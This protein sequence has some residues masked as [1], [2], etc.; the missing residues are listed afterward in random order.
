MSFSPYNNLLNYNNVSGVLTANAINVR[1]KLVLGGPVWSADNVPITFNS[2]VLFN[3]GF[4]ISADVVNQ[5]N[6]IVVGTPT[7][8]TIQSAI[9][10]FAGMNAG[11]TTITI[12]PGIYEEYIS[13]S[14]CSSG[15]N[16]QSRDFN[17]NDLLYAENVRGLQIIGDNR[18]YIPS[19][20][21]INGYENAGSSGRGRTY[22]ITTTSPSAGPFTAYIASS[23]GAVSGIGPSGAQVGNPLFGGS[24]L[25]NV[26]L[27][28][29]IALMQRGGGIGFATKTLNAQNGGGVGA[30]AAIIYNNVGTAILS[31]GGTNDAVTIPAY[32]VSLADGLTLNNLITAN[33]GIQITIS[34][35]DPIYD[36]PLGTNYAFSQILING[37]RDQLTINMV[38]PLPDY[39]SNIVA[40]PSVLVNPDFSN[41]KVGV[42]VGDRIAIS[43]SD[44]N[45]N[46][47]KSLHTIT[48]VSGNV[49]TISP[50]VDPVGSGGVDFSVAGSSVTF[51]PNVCISPPFIPDR[52]FTPLFS[53]NNVDF[54]MNGI[55]LDQNASQPFSAVLDGF[56][57]TGGVVAA[58]N[59]AVTDFFGT[60]ANSLGVHL[61]SGDAYITDGY[62]GGNGRWAVVGWS[63]GVGIST[64]STLRYGSVFATNI[65]QG[66]GFGASIG[67][68]VGLSNL[69]I[70]GCAGL[71]QPDAGAG[72]ILAGGEN[73][74]D[75]TL[76][77]DK[78]L[79][80][81]DVWGQGI[82]LFNGSTCIT[83]NPSIRVDRC[84][85]PT[86]GSN[87]TGYGVYVDQGS[88]MIIGRGGFFSTGGL[89]SQPR[90]TSY[91]NDCASAGPGTL[92]NVGI[93]VA[94]G[95]SF[96]ANGQMSFSGN[97]LDVQT[98]R[99]GSYSSPYDAASLGDVYALTG[100]GIVNAANNF[101]K[102]S[103]GGVGVTDVQLDLSETF[104]LDSLWLGK[105]ITFISISA[106]A[107]TITLTTGTFLNGN[108]VYTF[109]PV[110]GSSVTIR[111]LSASTATI[112]DS[113]TATSLFSDS[114]ANVIDVSASA[115]PTV[116]Q[117]LTATSATT[118]EWQTPA[119]P[120]ATP[121]S[122]L[123]SGANTN[124]INIGAAANPVGGQVLMSVDANNAN[125]QTLIYPPA[126]ELFSG[127]NTNT[128]DVGSAA[129]PTAG[130]VLTATSAIAAVWQ[131][132][133]VS[134]LGFA[135]FY[136]LAPADYGATIALG[137]SMD[138]P[139]AG[140]VGGTSLIARTGPGDFE[141]SDVGTYDVSW[142]TSIDE[143]GQLQL[144]LNAVIIPYSTAGRATGTSLI[145]NRVLVTT[146]APASVLNLV[147]PAGNAA[148]LTVTP[149][150]G[151]TE[152]A[153][154][155]LTIVRVA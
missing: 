68:Q 148:A 84:Y 1:K 79:H 80:V 75:A 49:L 130:Q 39:D 36:P 48:A 55:W 125:W 155:T 38:G 23:F 108:I 83:N 27:P 93:Y 14:G 25:S 123:Y 129:N 78:L 152:P 141:L 142:S 7:Y 71:F 105:S 134:P 111:V 116:G 115:N 61:V 66:F 89:A 11:K 153:A 21:Y 56:L 139:S 3:A 107:H 119:A 32:G 103:I 88:K 140:P 53:S 67:S 60:S 43:D 151:G 95:G 99:T 13:L 154:S 35:V 73:F 5:D 74:A 92:P 91:V 131:T 114:G 22:Q 29:Q 106:F 30:A 15:R 98:I 97:D 45:G 59:I 94:E 85:Y 87:T 82:S 121:A 37:A 102:Q 57:F 20:A 33:P 64:N 122:D 149:S 86:N 69:Q 41:A 10:A 101:S 150:A 128:I 112:V 133:S 63:R 100:P 50:P 28:N 6:T 72:I 118:A 137:A 110:A 16:V 96:Q 120:P 136:G 109:P 104:G 9:D 2:A 135:M 34:P 4:K 147:N 81:A 132:P 145:S 117:V 44:L 42:V 24:P 19:K 17:D 113:Q 31:M 126:P 90:L 62:R 46:L 8:P 12:P 65:R 40:V 143:P 58:N 146:V 124:V 77:V 52:P 127:G 144:A 70:M 138:F 18:P 51:L 26:F 47:G 76:N 54:S